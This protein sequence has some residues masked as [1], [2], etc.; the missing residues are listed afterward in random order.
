MN[1]NA[2][3]TPLGWF[4]WL[5]RMLVLSF[6]VD[7]CLVWFLQHSP[8]HSVEDHLHHG[9]KHGS[10]HIPWF[11]LWV[12]F[13]SGMGYSKVLLHTRKWSECGDH[14]LPYAV[15]QLPCRLPGG[16][17]QSLGTLCYCTLVPTF[18]YITTIKSS[19]FQFRKVEW[20]TLLLNWLTCKW[21]HCSMF[22]IAGK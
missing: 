17:F 8:P 21:D 1:V 12:C 16:S 3:I 22:P 19:S 4:W 18:H 9:G 11:N 15:Y 14:T 5:H 7:S 13:D 2:I 20:A 10:S 6:S